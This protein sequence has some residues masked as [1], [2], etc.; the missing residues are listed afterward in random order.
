MIGCIKTDSSGFNQQG[1]A[2]SVVQ[3]MLDLIFRIVGG[4]AFLYF[5]YGSFLVLTSQADPERLNHG[6]QTLYGAIVGL[7]NC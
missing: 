3:A 5:I 1:A 6:R 7:L 4:I 2:A